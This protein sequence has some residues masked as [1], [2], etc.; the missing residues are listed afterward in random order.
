MTSVSCE[1]LYEGSVC[2]EDRDDEHFRYGRGKNQ[3]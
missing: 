2:V 3:Q 1:K